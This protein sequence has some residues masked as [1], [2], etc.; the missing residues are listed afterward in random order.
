MLKIIQAHSEITCD[1]CQCTFIYEEI[2][3]PYLLEILEIEKWKSYWSK[4][5]KRFLHYCPECNAKAKRATEEMMERV[6]N[7]LESVADAPW[8][9]E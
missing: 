6:K 1:S 2:R 7:E 8:R 9:I 4:G 3:L 5:Q